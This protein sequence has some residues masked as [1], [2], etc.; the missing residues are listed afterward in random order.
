M[1]TTVVGAQR[2]AYQANSGS[3][4]RREFSEVVG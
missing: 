1:D 2:A 4:S 3:E